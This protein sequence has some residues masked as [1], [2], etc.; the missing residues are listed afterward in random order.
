MEQCIFCKEFASSNYIIHNSLA[1]TRKD[2]FPVSL[3]HCEIVPIRHVDSIF[4][5]TRKELLACSQ[6]LTEQQSAIK[7]V[8]PDVTGFNI[9]INDGVSAG[10]TIQH[11]HIHLIPR[12][13]GDVPNP[14][15]GIRGVIPGKQVYP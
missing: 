1:F 15:G 7:R 11:C 9:G 5:L 12:R 6:L 3:G 13:E 8:L 10:Q 2:N 4:K 14:K